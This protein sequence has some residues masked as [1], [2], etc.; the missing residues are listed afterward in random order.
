MFL[1]FLSHNLWSLYLVSFSA[2]G[3]HVDVLGRSEQLQEANSIKHVFL[4]SL[5]KAQNKICC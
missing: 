1:L 4:L 5:L 2:M 3:L